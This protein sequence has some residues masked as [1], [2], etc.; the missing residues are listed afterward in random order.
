MD[1]I[2]LIASSVPWG[3]WQFWA[4]TLLAIG[5]AVMIIRPMLPS[6]APK[7]GCPGCGPAAPPR[8]TELTV[9]GRRVR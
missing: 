3:D 7:V 4:V 5:A 9:D 8:K 1:R 6:R 2:A